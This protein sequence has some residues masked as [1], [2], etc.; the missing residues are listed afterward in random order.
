MEIEFLGTGAGS[1]S[2]SSNVTATA[3]KLLDECNSI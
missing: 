3:L 1:P 2:K